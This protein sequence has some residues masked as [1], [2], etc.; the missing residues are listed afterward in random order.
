[1]KVI[2][3]FFIIINFEKNINEIEN[4]KKLNKLLVNLNFWSWHIFVS[5]K[6]KSGFYHVYCL[7]VIRSCIGYN[8]I[9][10]NNL[11]FYIRNKYEINTKVDLCRKFID[12]K[13]SLKYI[14]KELRN[15]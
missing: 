8:D 1:M 3:I 2:C 4:L 11:L 5:E 14:F 6:Y 13:K 12:V 15:K 10:N 9:I 7:L